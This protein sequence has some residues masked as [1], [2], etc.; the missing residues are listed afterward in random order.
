MILWLLFFANGPIRSLQLIRIRSPIETRGCKIVERHSRN[1]QTPGA[2]RQSRGFTQDQLSKEP[3]D[4]LN[5]PP[6][7]QNR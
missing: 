3:Y 4:N 2:P 5:R 1:C 7:R 6:N